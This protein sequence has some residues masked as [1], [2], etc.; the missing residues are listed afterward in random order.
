MDM[1][2]PTLTHIQTVGDAIGCGGVA[3][4][5]GRVDYGYGEA[6]IYH[7]AFCN[8]CDNGSAYDNTDPQYQ[9]FKIVN[10]FIGQYVISWE[11]PTQIWSYIN[12]KVNQY[13]LSY[14]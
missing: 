14:L 5:I 2:E 10:R 3:G 9:Y 1:I 7:I 6:N 4:D 13:D 8:P 12:Q 11:T